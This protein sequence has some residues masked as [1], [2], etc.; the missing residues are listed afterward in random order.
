MSLKA[1]ASSPTSA[2]GLRIVDAAAGI[3]RVDAAH[4][5]R[6]A[7]ERDEDAPQQQRR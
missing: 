1:L 5:A 4:R 3:V 2:A 6:Q 7:L